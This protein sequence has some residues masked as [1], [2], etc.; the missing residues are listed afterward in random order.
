MEGNFVTDILAP[1]LGALIMAIASGLLIA[2]P[3]W[4]GRTC[5]RNQNSKE[6]NH[7]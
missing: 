2:Y 7:F 5:S 6:S 3:N 1:V 4:A